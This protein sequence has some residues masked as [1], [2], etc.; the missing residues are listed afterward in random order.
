[1]SDNGGIMTRDEHSSAI[2]ALFEKV[3]A[4]AAVA[5]IKPLVDE[6][7]VRVLQ[8]AMDMAKAGE[9]EG[10]AFAGTTCDGGSVNL[11]HCHTRVMQLL[12][13]VAVLQRDI[14]DLKIDL[15]VPVEPAE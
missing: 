9:L 7:L 15:R 13:E 1:M 5:P 6:D 14:M 8:Q 11:F 2:A 10:F 12:G 3:S 4:P